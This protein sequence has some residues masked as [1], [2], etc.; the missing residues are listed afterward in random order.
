MSNHKVLVTGAAGYLGRALRVALVRRGIAAIGC[1][2]AASGDLLGVDLANPEAAARLF[3]EVRPD[4]VIHAAAVLPRSA[5]DYGDDAQADLN[6]AM[7]RS[8]ADAGPA[9]MVFVS[10]MTVYGEPIRNPVRESDAAPLSSYAWSKYRGE[11]Y[12][13][14]IRRDHVAP[15]LPGLFGLPRRNGLIGNVLRATLSGDT[16][17]LPADPVVWSAMHVEDAAEVVIRLALTETAQ[18]PISVGYPG[19]LSIDRFVALAERLSGRV[20]PRGP[21]QPDFELDLGLAARFGALPEATFE[22]RVR[23]F[24]QALANEQQSEANHDR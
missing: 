23:D 6:L 3:A 7:L 1:D 8:V 13:A 14:E 24:A 12:L 16:P 10:S 4:V 15:R 17:T 11:G 5:G 18:G 9:R 19:V 21:I 22:S 20:L 2:V